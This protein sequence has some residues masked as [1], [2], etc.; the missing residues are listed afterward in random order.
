MTKAERTRQLIIEKAAPIINQ[1]GMAATAISDIMKATKLAKGGIYGNFE[2]KDEICREV[3]NYLFKGLSAKID[4][5]LINKRTAKDKLFTLLDYHCDH[6]AL[7]ETGGCPMLNFG[8][9]ADDNDV[10]IKKQVND[11]IKASQSRISELVEDGIRA[12]EFTITT[13][14]QEF[15][16]KAFAIMEGGILISRIQSNNQQMKIIIEALKAEIIQFSK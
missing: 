2:D 15:G 5:A 4:G 12:G 8:T 11:A 16:I 7:S 6:L 13:S 3:F 14:A 9:E 1:K 10:I